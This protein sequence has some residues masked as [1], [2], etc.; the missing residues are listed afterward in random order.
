MDVPQKL[1]VPVAL[2]DGIAHDFLHSGQVIGKDGIAFKAGIIVIDHHD[3]NAQTSDL[4][5][6]RG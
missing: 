2:P 1:K 3:R 5:Q 4:Y 6:N